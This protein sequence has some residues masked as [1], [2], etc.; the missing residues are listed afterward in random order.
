VSAD[1]TA[2]LAEL[3]QMA[4]VHMATLYFRLP[5]RVDSRV[6]EILGIVGRLKRGVPAK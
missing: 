2:I 6:W 5:A 1:K 4:E 3:R